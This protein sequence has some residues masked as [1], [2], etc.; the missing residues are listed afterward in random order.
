MQVVNSQ[1]V[2]GLKPQHE[3]NYIFFAKRSSDLPIVEESNSERHMLE[4]DDQTLDND[5]NIPSKS[6]LV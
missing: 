4:A 6:N 2:E 5:Y 1:V 3:E